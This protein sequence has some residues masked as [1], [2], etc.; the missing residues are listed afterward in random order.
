[1]KEW[2]KKKTIGTFRHFVENLP[3]I[4]RFADVCRGDRSL[5]SRVVILFGVLVVVVVVV[6][7]FGWISLEERKRSWRK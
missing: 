5:Y 4:C 7:L 6:G 3:N 2:T 1:M